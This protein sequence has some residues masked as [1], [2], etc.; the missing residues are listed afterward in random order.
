[1]MN[2][3][4]LFVP[5]PSLKNSTHSPPTYMSTPECLQQQC[6][7]SDN[8][9]QLTCSLCKQEHVTFGDTKPWFPNFSVMNLIGHVIPKSKHF[10]ETHHH[11]KCYYCLDDKQL[12][13][14]YCAYHGEHAGHNCEHMDKAR[15]AVDRTLWKVKVKASGECT[16]GRHPDS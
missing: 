12:V 8:Q 6:S 1:M 11:E 9:T 2:I 14:I 13:C 10:C 3:V 15:A 7:T 4:S 5:H 16:C